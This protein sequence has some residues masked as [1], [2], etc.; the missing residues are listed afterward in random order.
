[1][2]LCDAVTEAKQ[3]KVTKFYVLPVCSLSLQGWENV[4]NALHVVVW[5]HPLPLG[6]ATLQVALGFGH[7]ADPGQGEEGFQATVGAQLD[8]RVEAVAHHQA[9]GGVHAVLGGHALKHVLVGFAHRLGLALSGGLHSLQQAACT[10][11][12]CEGGDALESF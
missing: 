1:M 11:K 7:R 9:A 10:W 3:W 8:V 4:S 5:H 6:A 2:S 12:R